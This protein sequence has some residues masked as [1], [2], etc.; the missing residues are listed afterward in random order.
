[1]H[2]AADPQHRCCTA[3]AV[4]Q[5]SRGLAASVPAMKFQS[6]CAREP[7]GRQMLAQAN[8]CTGKRLHSS[9]SAAAM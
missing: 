1:M 3:L 5:S 9:E 2:I 4:M 7:E 8:A 6:C